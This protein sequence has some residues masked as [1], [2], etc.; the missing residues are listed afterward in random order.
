MPRT[1]ISLG[2]AFSMLGG[3][4]LAQS[5][6]IGTPT[7]SQGANTSPATEGTLN[8]NH[9]SSAMSQNKNTTPPASG[10]T[11]ATDNSMRGD[12]AMGSGPSHVNGTPSNGSTSGTIDGGG[13]TSNG[14]SG[15]SK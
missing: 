10:S 3:L 11:E 12:N 2:L 9:G 13:N 8:G 15:S 6:S 5:T 7:G 1:L 14:A 4:A